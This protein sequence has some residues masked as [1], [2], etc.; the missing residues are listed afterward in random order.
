[1]KKITLITLCCL[2]PL[3]QAFDDDLTAP[4]VD[5]YIELL[6]AR[7]DM[8]DLGSDNSDGGRARV[9]LEFND[10]SPLGWSFRTEISLNQLGDASDTETT[11]RPGL[12]SDQVNGGPTPQEVITDVTTS[13]RLTGIEVG[14][15]LYDNRLFY[16]RG[17]AFVYSAKSRVS[18]QKTLTF[19]NEDDD[20]SSL[21]PA[22]S[23]ESRIGPYLGLGLEREIVES[24]RGVAE[25]NYY[26]VDG[27]MLPS[28]SLGLQFRF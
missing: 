24:V 28:L 17:G 15:R 11:R 4:D 10:V 21:L 7:T 19:L 22:E 5:F 2:S 14:T 25:I 13:L 20:T 23:T 12:P 3:V 27:E 8:S 1:M 6:G 18:T 26:R 16:I 9:G